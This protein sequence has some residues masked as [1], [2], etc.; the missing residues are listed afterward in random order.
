MTMPATTDRTANPS[1][2][3]ILTYHQVDAI[4]ARGA[5]FR[6]IYV[7]PAAFAR[8]MG[9]LKWMGYQGLSMSALMPYLR[10]ERTGK[11]VGITFDDGYLNNLQ[12]ALPALAHHGFS[13]TCFAVSQLLGKTNAWDLEVGIAQTPLMSDSQIRQWVAGGQEIGAHTR[14]HVRLEQADAAN[15]R[16][17]IRLCKTELE[18]V[19]DAPVNHFCYPYGEFSA[20]HTEM[21][22]DAGYSSAT[23]TQRSR[24]HHGEDMMLL[25]RVPVLNTTTQAM[26]WLKLA[27]T[28][29]DRRRA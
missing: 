18:A 10:G 12:H 9:L 6:G 7:T 22:R 15:C 20:L 11:V 16:A 2:I 17:E 28:Y 26:L 23:T 27:T 21:A 3:A 5:P 25:P 14:H 24:C 19:I 4:P 1:P 8:Q 13:S 29:E